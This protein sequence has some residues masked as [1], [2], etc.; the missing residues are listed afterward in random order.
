MTQEGQDQAATTTQEGQNGMSRL[1]MPSRI[2]SADRGS[3]PPSPRFTGSLSAM[4][5]RPS[6]AST[7][8]RIAVKPREQDM[9]AMGTFK[10]QIDA[11]EE[12]VSAQISRAQH[13]SDKLR[14]AALARIDAKMASMEGM[15]PKMERRIAEMSGNF[16]GLSDEM[17][18]QIRRTDQMDSRLWEW[19]QKFEEEIRAKFSEIEQNYHQV[20]SSVRVATASFDDG[21]KRCGRRLVR[22]EGLV[23][24]R[25]ASVDDINQSLLNLHERTTELEDAKSQDSVLFKSEE[26]SLRSS[27]APAPEQPARE[28]G[29]LVALDSRVTEA[30]QRLQEWQQESHE[31]HARL[32][33]QEERLKSLRT[34]I[35]AK[36]EHYRW[37]N[38][39]VERA[40]WEGRFKE[41]Q[42]QVKDLDQ[43]RVGHTEELKI[44][45]Q[46]V[47]RQEE[48]H[49]AISD[50]VRRL[51][52]RNLALNVDSSSAGPP[53]EL[54]GMENAG[55][56]EQVTERL[57]ASEE[58][59]KVLTSEVERMS[60][61]DSMLAS[62]VVALVEQLKQVA[63]KVMQH[64]SSLRD[65]AAQ[66]GKLEVELRMEQQ[67]MEETRNLGHLST[68][69]QARLSR[70]EV[71]LDRI[72]LEVE[73][74]ETSEASEVEVG[75][76]SAP[77][78]EEAKPLSPLSR[79]RRASSTE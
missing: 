52:E 75:D 53:E 60:Q 13:Q 49:E 45:Q 6:R 47:E 20:S 69:V 38:D 79:T 50:Q 30:T 32:E 7:P 29:A 43:N 58:A 74:S 72:R 21:M 66:T 77:V 39:R 78:A 31:T 2:D 65:L 41:L 61:G 35:E 27:P 59:V 48:A 28:D 11:M 25:L 15:Q 16:K 42:A 9:A 71:E 33:A 73:G 62:R 46:R 24:E 64:D 19:R 18:S 44:A 14:D 22:L 34:L 63:P 10:R 55:L 56:S 17:Q 23:D 51:Q 1:V 36:E 26:L 54:M 8:G 76:E 12:K 70:L 67:S 68:S 40:D 4:T 57:S 5:Q 3:R 37:L